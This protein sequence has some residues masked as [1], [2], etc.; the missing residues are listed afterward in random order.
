MARFRSTPLIKDFLGF[1]SARP[2][3]ESAF[4]KSIYIV[5]I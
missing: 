1:A 3:G 5:A 4:I 2:T